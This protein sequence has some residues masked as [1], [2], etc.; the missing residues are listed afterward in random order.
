MKKRLVKDIEELEEIFINEIKVVRKNPSFTQTIYSDGL[1]SNQ[2]KNVLILAMLK[3]VFSRKSDDEII[4]SY[5][6]SICSL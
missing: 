2:R 1:A 5:W 4:K 3:R 6:K